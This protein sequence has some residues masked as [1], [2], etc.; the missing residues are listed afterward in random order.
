MT[1][2]LN[3]TIGCDASDQWHVAEFRR[4][5]AVTAA[6]GTSAIICSSEGVPKVAR[7]EYSPHEMIKDYCRAFVLAGEGPM[8][9]RHCWWGD[10]GPAGVYHPAGFARTRYLRVL[11]KTQILSGVVRH[12]LKRSAPEQFPRLYTPMWQPVPDHVRE[13]ASRKLALRERK[14][15]RS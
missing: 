8:S 14:A 1:Y 7:T 3:A 4:Q 10:H 2:E 5:R 12:I 11:I 6:L 13:A 9:L 15:A